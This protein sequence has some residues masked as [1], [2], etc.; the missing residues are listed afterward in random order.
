MKTATHGYFARVPNSAEGEAFIDQMR[1]YM[2]DGYYI[3]VLH[4]GPRPNHAAHTKAR[5]AHSHR[6]YLDVQYGGRESMRYRSL[7]AD[8]ILGHQSTVA[9]L[10]Q[11]IAD[12]EDKAM[13]PLTFVDDAFT[14][15]IAA[16]LNADVLTINSDVQH[17]VLVITDDT[18]VAYHDLACWDGQC[19]ECG[20][21]GIGAITLADGESATP[22]RADNP[23]HL[24]RAADTIAA[25]RRTLD[26]IGEERERDTE[27]AREEIGNRQDTIDDLENRLAH[28]QRDAEEHHANY[29]A[30]YDT[31][32]ESQNRV[33]ELETVNARWRERND[34][35]QLRLA[36]SEQ[37]AMERH[38]NAETAS[39]KVTISIS[40]E[41]R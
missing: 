32:A 37:T 27:N 3:R 41:E 30:A 12:A 15:R 34:A 22:Y 11:D 38:V 2:S 1:R 18:V 17:R 7:S 29:R 36:E 16:T 26:G 8:T 35:L 28:Y 6:L 24:K 25:L 21:A 10:R 20:G 5:E 19:D 9:R 33:G 40:V 13:P 4:S 23:E 39:A 14:Q 31:L